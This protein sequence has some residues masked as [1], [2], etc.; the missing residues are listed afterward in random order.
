MGNPRRNIEHFAA[1]FVFVIIT[2]VF[3]RAQF[4]LSSITGRVTDPSG[5]I[6]PGAQVKI[7]NITTTATRV[8]QTNVSGLYTFPSLPPGSY[9]ISVSLQGFK[10]VTSEVKLG[11][12]QTLSQDFKL[13]VGSM[14]QK[15][16]VEGATSAVSL[17][18]E[19]HIRSERGFTTT[20]VTGLGMRVDVN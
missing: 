14:S 15:A 20:P 5:S 11:I 12:I 10:E 13:R 17:Q 19:S 4:T 9:E 3:A 18:A 16:R 1:A 2:A 8:V 6:V 7:Q